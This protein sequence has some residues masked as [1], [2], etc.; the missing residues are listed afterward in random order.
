MAIDVDGMKV[1]MK[2]DIYEMLKECEQWFYDGTSYVKDGKTVNLQPFAKLQ[3]L[4]TNIQQKLTSI[5]NKL[6]TIEAD[7]KKI[8]QQL[9]LS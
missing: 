1:Q 2:R 9:G 4:S 5:D 8:K 3:S 6:T 7:I